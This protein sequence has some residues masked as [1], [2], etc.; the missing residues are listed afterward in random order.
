VI[1]PRRMKRRAFALAC[2]VLVAPFAAI[3]AAE[4]GA[5]MTNSCYAM[6]TAFQRNRS[7]VSPAEGKFIGARADRA[8]DRQAESGE[9]LIEPSRR[10]G[11]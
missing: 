7:R 6:D 10:I 5:P 8:G 1:Q 4:D 9:N 3:L 11:N 2:S